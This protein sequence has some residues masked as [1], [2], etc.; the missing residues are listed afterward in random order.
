MSYELWEDVLQTGFWLHTFETHCPPMRL[1]L[2]LL[3]I[4]EPIHSEMPVYDE[5]KQSEVNP[6]KPYY[7]EYV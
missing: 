2:W 5:D 6:E 7:A 3:G 4:M 1:L